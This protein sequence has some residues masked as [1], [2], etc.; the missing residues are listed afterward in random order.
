MSIYYKE[1]KINFEHCLATL[2]AQSLPPNEVVLVLD[3]K[4]TEE[5]YL[6]ISNWRK[7]LPIVLVELEKNVG[8]GKAL[9]IGL[10]HCSFELVAR[11][12]TDDLCTP[13]RFEKQVKQ[14]LSNPKL[15]ICGSYIKEFDESPNKPLSKRHTP[16]D[17][18]SIKKSC[19]FI[20]PFNHMTVMYRKTA[21]EN[22]GGYLHM[23]WMEDW[24]LWLRMLANDC[25]A[26]NLPEYLVK[27]R[28]GF[29]M[30]ERRSGFDYIKSEWAMT[31]IKISL[32]L[33][34]WPK[35]ILIFFVRSFPRVVPKKSLF[36]IY[37]LS[38]RYIK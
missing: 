12:D 17:H 14:F 5:L 27:A 38:R 32:K 6:V 13:F 2:C 11:M 29:S 1:S 26:I 24:Y 22:A 10:K 3:G 36:R 28:T 18:D 30:I 20:N 7:R 33:V 8:L 15:D 23:P 19:I 35:A 9:N 34:T 37:K 21:V 25:N 16:L 31:K 4:L